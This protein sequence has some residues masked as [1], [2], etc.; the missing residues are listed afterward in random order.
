MIGRRQRNAADRAHGAAASAWLSEMGK[1]LDDQAE[2][3][4][5][6]VVVTPAAPI[7]LIDAGGAPTDRVRPLVA[8]RAKRASKGRSRPK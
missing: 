6:Q 8:A 3:D 5:R 2:I 4:V 1:A 7:E